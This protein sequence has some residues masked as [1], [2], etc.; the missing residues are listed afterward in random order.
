MKKSEKSLL[1]ELRLSAKKDKLNKIAQKYINHI[2]VFVGLTIL[3]MLGSTVYSV[4]SKR[5]QKLYSEKFY[6]AI[7]SLQKNNATKGMEIFE[8]IYN[9]KKAPKSI[10]SIS[11]I[12]LARLE[13]VFGNDEKA[14]KLYKEIYKNNKKFFFVRYLAGTSAVTIMINQQNESGYVE[15]EE[16]LEKLIVDKNPLQNLTTEQKGIFE[17]QRGNLE[18]G[19]EV[20]N[21]LLK[22]SDLDSN[23]RSRIEK[24]I[25]A[26]K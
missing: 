18:K 4:I 3:L 1:R 16:L 8:S 21:S 11:G 26:Y 25:K 2:L 7:E 12:K 20:L 6:S 9:D 24:I 5:R 19:V 22:K 10:R 14:I 17:L 13:S 23:A 15:I